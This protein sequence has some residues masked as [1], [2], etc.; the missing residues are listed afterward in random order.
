[1][2]W[3]TIIFFV[4]IKTIKERKGNQVQTSFLLVV[5]AYTPS[6]HIY[7][8]CYSDNQNL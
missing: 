6:E 1:M 4:K 8:L 3:F 7:Q 2:I 5:K